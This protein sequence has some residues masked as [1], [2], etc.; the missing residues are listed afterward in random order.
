[1]CMT[2]SLFQSAQVL[3]KRDEAVLPGVRTLLHLCYS[4]PICSKIQE[5]DLNGPLNDLMTN[6][7]DLRISDAA[8]GCLARLGGLRENH[9]LSK[10]GHTISDL[11]SLVSPTKGEVAGGEGQQEFNVFLS[12]RRS[13]SKVRQISLIALFACQME[14]LPLPV[15]LFHD[16]SRTLSPK[17]MILP[18]LLSV[19]GFRSGVV[20]PADAA[21]VHH[22]PG[23]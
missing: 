12:H 21:R 14:L 23:L 15:F 22:L 16:V 20:Q 17:H 19:P 6:S 10:R 2:L 11:M 8:T 5:V 13:D 9:S 1:M 7:S 4:P 18:A 3:E